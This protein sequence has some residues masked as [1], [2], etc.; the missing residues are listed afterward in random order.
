MTLPAEW[1]RQAFVQLTW[2]H[3]LTDW[4]DVLDEALLC[5]YALAREIALREQL[6]IV[7][8]DMEEARL[9]LES[10]LDGRVP[11]TERIPEQVLA[12]R[13]AY[14]ECDTNDTWARDHA[15]IS[16]IHEGNV[17]LM[18]F[19]FNGWGMKFPA[20]HDNLINGCLQCQGVI[21]DLY[22]QTTQGRL[23]A[24]SYVDCLDFV[25][26]GGS[27]ESDGEGTLMTTTSCLLAPNR[28]EPM[29][30][31]DIEKQ[32]KQLFGLKRVLW[33]E[34]G[35]VSGDD[36]DEHIDTLARFCPGQVIAYVA[37]DD[38]KHPDYESL[39]RMEQQLKSFRTI[40]GKPYRLVPLPAADIIDDQEG[41][42]QPATYANFLILNNSVLYP[43]YRQPEKDELAR[44][45]L[46]QALPGYELVAIDCNVLVGQHGSLHCSTM[47]YPLPSS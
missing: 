11:E 42:P 17:L 10:A 14:A 19:R 47:Q 44:Q 9:Q 40:E 6:L 23:P 13:I 46:A 31:T 33:I 34:H 39:K 15:F 1:H 22:A 26:E 20:N 7:A 8:Q 3:R 30:R 5:F 12:F 27:I 25:L 37:T 2:P 41:Y 24:A 36:T 45:Q 16:C 38:K 18:N 28:N 4:A 21:D 32:L 35:Q 43:T 29:T